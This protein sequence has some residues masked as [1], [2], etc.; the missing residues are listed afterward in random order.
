LEVLDLAERTDQRGGGTAAIINRSQ[1]IPLSG[2][3][4]NRAEFQRRKRK[5]SRIFFFS[6]ISFVSC[7]SKIF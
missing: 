2:R 1:R 6:K 7:F 4:Q 3:K 5:K